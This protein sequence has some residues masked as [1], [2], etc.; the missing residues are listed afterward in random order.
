LEKGTLGFLNRN[1]SCAGKR[2]V[3]AK[4]N[5]N[6]FALTSRVETPRKN[7]EEC[8]T[9]YTAYLELTVYDTK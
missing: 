9:Y 1:L 6:G 3:D 8:I 2:C 7:N 4:G 5:N